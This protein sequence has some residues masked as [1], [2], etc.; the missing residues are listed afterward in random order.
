M[1]NTR[2]RTGLVNPEM[3]ML[4]KYLPTYVLVYM[5]NYSIARASTVSESSSRHWSF[6]L[7]PMPSFRRTQNEENEERDRAPQRTPA[8][9]RGEGQKASLLTSY[10]RAQ[11]ISNSQIKTETSHCD[12]LDSFC[13]VCVF[14]SRF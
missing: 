14:V 5:R 4:F 1:K 9:R 8:P 11:S 13:G 10:L 12:T 6:L 7:Q 2:R 3:L